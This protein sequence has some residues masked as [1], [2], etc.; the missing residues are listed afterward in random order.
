MKKILLIFF[1]FFIGLTYANAQKLQFCYIA[2]DGGLNID[3]LLGYLG[4]IHRLAQ[5]DDPCIFYLSNGDKPYIAYYNIENNHQDLSTYK[6][7]LGKL[8]ET[9]ELSINASTDVEN[10][11]SI[12]EKIDI[13][14]AIYKNVE[15]NFFITPE[16]W[17]RYNETIIATSY[18]I[19][20]IAEWKQA[21]FKLKIYNVSDK[22][23][24]IDK[25]YP[26]GLLNLAP[27]LNNKI[28]LLN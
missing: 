24:Q 21:D 19:L 3:K 15:W 8:Q 22:R 26:F 7:I 18:F 11:V 27:Q 12:F 4:D 23:L 2:H 1:V 25:E 17:N 20:N 28:I 14:N 10:I 16:Y 6:E 5:I 13:D 9:G